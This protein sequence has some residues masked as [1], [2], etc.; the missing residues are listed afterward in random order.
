MITYPPVNSWSELLTSALWPT[1]ALDG[2]NAGE[3]MFVR[4]VSNPAQNRAP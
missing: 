4:N 1:Q 2:R 3:S